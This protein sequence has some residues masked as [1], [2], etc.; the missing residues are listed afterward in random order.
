MTRLNK[1]NLLTGNTGKLKE[2]KKWLEPLG[3]EVVLLN[4]DFMETQVGS[5]EEVIY[6]GMKFIGMEGEIKEPFIKDDSGLFID[7]LH[8]FPGVYS[9]YVHSS[10]GNAGILRL[11]DGMAN[12]SARFRTVIGLM[13]PDKGVSMFIGECEGRISHEARGK[14]GFGYDPI[15]I[16]EGE[17]RTFAEMSVIDKNEMSHR[18]KAIKGLVEFLSN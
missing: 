13:I 9:S 14:Q 10:I 18:I 11:M 17:E 8:G 5:L 16:P 4:K 1:I 2:I 6:Q 15:F 7:A 12:R 3:I